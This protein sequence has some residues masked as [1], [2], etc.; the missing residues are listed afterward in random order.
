MIV[1]LQLIPLYTSLS[2]QEIYYD[3]I[4]EVIHIS[5]SLNC[6]SFNVTYSP[7]QCGI[8]QSKEADILA[9]VGAQT[10]RK[11]IKE[12][13]ISLATANFFCASSLVTP[14]LVVAVQPCME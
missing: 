5:N 11:M 1:L 7:A 6:F 4:G 13:E 3:K 2:S 14:C 8:T 9:K 10:A 12:Q